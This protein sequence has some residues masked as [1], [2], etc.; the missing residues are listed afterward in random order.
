MGNKVKMLP[1]A[2]S[3]LL[4]CALSFSSLAGSVDRI[5]LELS[6]DIRTGEEGG[7]VDVFTDSGGCYVESVEIMKAPSRPWQGDD[8][9]MIRV[10]LSLDEDSFFDSGLSEDEIT[11][12]GD[13]GD[14]TNVTLGKDQITVYIQLD[15]LEGE[16][17]NDKL[18][19]QDSSDQAMDP[20]ESADKESEE[21]EDGSYD[22]DV[23]GL[24]WEE[25]TGTAYWD[26]VPDAREYEVRLYRDG[27]SVTS[28]KTTSRAYYDFSDE[29]TGRGDYL[30]RIRAI[31]SSSVKG[32]WEE[33]DEWYVSSGEAEEIRKKGGSSSERSSSDESY[34][35][36]ASGSLNPSTQADASGIWMWDE[37]VGRWWYC[38]W[39]K[40][41]PADCWQ[42][43]DGFWYFFDGQGYMVT[44]WVLSQDLW[45][46]CDDS[47]F[48]L[49]DAT[50]PD[51]Y[52][53]D[54]DGVWIQ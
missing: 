45:Y 34:S 7:S 49:T 29:F 10:V 20:G 22:L 37:T 28:V 2:G 47:G 1:W 42:Y 40:T 53:V 23:S 24:G 11:L 4:S 13:G 9:P 14:V 8:E 32:S 50:T 48:M 54:E 51:G 19:G 41:Y 43:I 15:A 44:G 46:Y 33:S 27:D 5:T 39:D 26:D 3:I 6:S 18:S 52:E 31:R 21:D 30:F 36:S 12:K 35:D 38:N 17:V 25:D 16:T